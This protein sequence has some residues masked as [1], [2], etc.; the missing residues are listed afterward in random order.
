MTHASVPASSPFLEIEASRNGQRKRRA[1]HVFPLFS[2]SR[3]LARIA[4]ATSRDPPKLESL[5]TRQ[6]WA[7]V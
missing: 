6:A 5:L 2:L 3:L 7:D 1:L 4:R